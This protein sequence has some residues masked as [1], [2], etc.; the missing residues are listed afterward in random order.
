MKTYF[1]IIKSYIHIEKLK[2]QISM[3]AHAYVY[4]SILNPFIISIISFCNEIIN[5]L[6]LLFQ[7]ESSIYAF[8]YWWHHFILWK[9]G[10]LEK[11]LPV[12]VANCSIWK[13]LTTTECTWRIR[14]YSWKQVRMLGVSLRWKAKT[15][16]GTA[17]GHW[18]SSEIIW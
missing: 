4:S 17:N 5:N 7:D 2:S 11:V 14:Q 1:I 6:N 13:T 8:T 10:W 12:C 9:Y 3:C 15:G 16:N 18:T